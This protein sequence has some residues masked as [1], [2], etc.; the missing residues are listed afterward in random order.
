MFRTKHF[1]VEQIL[2]C[3]LMVTGAEAQ[4]RRAVVCDER[5]SALRSKPTMIAPIVQR[6][7]RGRVIRI[8]SG[9]QSRDG[10]VYLRVIV[11]QHRRGW[12]LSDAVIRS[13]YLKDAQR[14]LHMID[15]TNDGFMRVKL[16]RICADE[17]RGTD[18]AAS[19]LLLLGESADRMADQLTRQFLRRS[20]ARGELSRSVYLLNDVGLD[21]YN[22]IGIR[23]RIDPTGERLVYD[24]AAYR[25]LL[26]RYPRSPEALIVKEKRVNGTN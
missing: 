10:L 23:F 5:L 24:G 15:E 19:A 7:R 6:L 11:S 13:G 25:E 3:L 17:F 9:V 8:T 21:R 18:A 14:L 20:P 16:A 1:A 4:T 22:R 2:I 12:M 26:R